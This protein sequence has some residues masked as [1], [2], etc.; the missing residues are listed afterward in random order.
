[1]Q[2][3]PNAPFACVLR[4]MIFV[5]FSYANANVSDAAFPP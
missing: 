4:P 5:K 2:F 3:K 1:M